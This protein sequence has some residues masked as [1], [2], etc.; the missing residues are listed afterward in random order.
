MRPID[1]YRFY[2]AHA[3][4]G[5]WTPLAVGALHVTDRW[6]KTYSDGARATMSIVV[7]RVPPEGVAG[8]YLLSG[9]IAIVTP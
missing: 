3:A 5:G 7:L 8:T 4:R 6:T 9:G 2:G 1:V